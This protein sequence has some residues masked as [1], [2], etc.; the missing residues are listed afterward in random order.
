MQYL[1][2][3]CLAYAVLLLL[4]GVMALIWLPARWVMR[5]T[6]KKKEEKKW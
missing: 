5:K 1:M 3:A 4:M 2:G 6:R